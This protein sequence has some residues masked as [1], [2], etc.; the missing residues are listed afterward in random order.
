MEIAR[1]A[2]EALQETATL[3]NPRDRRVHGIGTAV[4]GVLVAA[5]VALHGL[6]EASPWDDVVTACYVLL[7]LGVVAWQ[8]RAARTVPRNARLVGY[9]G[10][11]LSVVAIMPVLGWTNWLEH[12]GDPHRLVVVAI[13]S[14]VAA[15]AAVAG[16]AIAAGGRR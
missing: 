3:D 8:T 2:S 4:A 5:Y 9:L 7:L 14:L 10:L 12:T 16:V 1:Q 13:A 15:P 6:V 11:G